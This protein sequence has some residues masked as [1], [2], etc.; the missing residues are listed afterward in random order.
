[1]APGT[2]RCA[3]RAD[4][5]LGLRMKNP[6]TPLP[7]PA[8]GRAQARVSRLRCRLAHGTTTSNR[9]LFGRG[10]AALRGFALRWAARC[11]WALRPWGTPPLRRSVVGTGA[12]QGALDVEDEGVSWFA[13]PCSR[14]LPYHDARAPAWEPK[15]F[16]GRRTLW[17][18]GRIQIETAN[19]GV[20]LLLRLLLFLRLWRG[21][22]R[23]RRLSLRCFARRLCLGHVLLAEQDLGLRGSDAL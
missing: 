12:S 3:R 10:L 22:R 15:G 9:G 18:Q 1:M 19:A 11:A 4:G 7:Q 16:D 23:F 6:R 14:L 5:G 17:G 2:N 13:R 20:I 21:T 8:L